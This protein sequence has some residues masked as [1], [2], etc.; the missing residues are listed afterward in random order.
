MT[1]EFCRMERRRLI[2]HYDQCA[3]DNQAYAADGGLAVAKGRL[4]FSLD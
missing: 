2:D 4:Q 1:E 3:G